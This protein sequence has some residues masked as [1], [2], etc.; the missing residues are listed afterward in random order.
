MV[1]AGKNIIAM[2]AFHA[3]FVMTKDAKSACAKRDMS[4]KMIL[5]PLRKVGGNIRRKVKF[6]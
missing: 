5:H 4:V 1:K 3:I 2:T 6:L